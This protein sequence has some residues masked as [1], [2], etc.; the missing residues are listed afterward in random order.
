MT[1]EQYRSAEMAALYQQYLA[2]GPLQYMTDLFGEMTDSAEDAG[3]LALSFYAPM[4]M[5]YSLYD[6]AEDKD[7]VSALLH[8]H[9]VRFAKE[10]S[11]L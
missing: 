11:F 5:L 6:G 4:F 3:M 10:R 2:A 1:L 7:T 8:T 9:I